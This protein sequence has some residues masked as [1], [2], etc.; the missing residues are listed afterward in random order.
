MPAT[1]D[2]QTRAVEAVRNISALAAL[3][4]VTAQIIAN[5]ENPK[6]SA[7]QLQKLVSNDPALATRILKIVNSSFYGLPGQ[8]SSIERAIV[9][10]GPCSVKNIAI[11]ASVGQMFRGA[12]LTANFAAKD[13]WIHCVAVAVACR[14]L[15]QLIEKPLADQ[16][17]LAGMLHDLGILASLQ[18]WPENLHAVCGTVERTSADFRDAELNQ[19]GTNHEFLGKALAAKWKF[20]VAIQSVAGFHHSPEQAPAEHQRLANIV[21][22]A[23]VIACQSRHGFN[24]TARSE[25][26]E[27]FAN[28]DPD[29][30]TQVSQKLDELVAAASS[31]IA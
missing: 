8:V 27:S 5:V 10:L 16:A 30:I 31:L 14:E 21:H 23:D 20:P 17:F 9:L 11:A 2:P 1:L 19:F 3:P 25:S 26:I 18:L 4:Q 7:A 24:L 6:G 15:A 13:V 28:I 12:R 29:V 22:A